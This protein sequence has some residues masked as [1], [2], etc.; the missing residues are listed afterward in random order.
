MGP[1]ADFLG[2]VLASTSQL[3]GVAQTAASFTP[4]DFLP[5]IFTALDRIVGMVQVSLSVN[6]MLRSISYYSLLQTM[7]GNKQAFMGPADDAISIITVLAYWSSKE[8]NSLAEEVGK[9]LEDSQE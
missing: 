2:R 7:R 5:G 4:L 9:N 3:L 1:E 8:G 6:Y